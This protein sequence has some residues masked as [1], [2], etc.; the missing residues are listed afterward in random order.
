MDTL[1]DIKIYLR[2]LNV[3]NIIDVATYADGIMVDIDSLT[4]MPDVLIVIIDDYS[5]IIFVQKTTNT[6]FVN[7]YTIH[8][9]KYGKRTSSNRYSF[10]LNHR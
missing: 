7:D 5:S 10:I 8:S 6:E 1:E 2:D 3:A 9:L 4:E